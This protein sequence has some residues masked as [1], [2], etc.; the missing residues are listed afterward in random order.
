MTPKK[1]YL[2]LSNFLYA[3]KWSYLRIDEAL[4]N[5]S[6]CFEFGHDLFWA[7]NFLI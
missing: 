7:Y 2:F 4:L 3:Y 5:N 1:L 6:L